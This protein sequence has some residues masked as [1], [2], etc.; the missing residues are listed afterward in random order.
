MDPTLLIFDKNIEKIGLI[1][2]YM[3]VII[4]LIILPFFL[5]DY[6]DFNKLNA[7][8]KE[9]VFEEVDFHVSG[10]SRS[11][12]TIVF[13]KNGD[14]LFFSTCEGLSYRICTHKDYWK[15]SRAKTVKVIE[16]SPKKVL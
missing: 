1:S 7:T 16:L 2:K 10:S 5:G 6:W 12:A 3:T 9:L 14:A 11:P 4:L 15:K 8:P 13:T